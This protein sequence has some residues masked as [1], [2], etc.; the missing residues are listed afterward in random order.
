[1]CC[2]DFNLLHLCRATDVRAE[3]RC[4][5]EDT[6]EIEPKKAKTTAV[7][8]IDRC[9]SPCSSIASNHHSEDKDT[10]LRSDD[11]NH[12][13]SPPALK[14]AKTRQAFQCPHCLYSAN[15]CSSLN[16][17]MRIHFPPKEQC[18]SP[19]VEE[20]F[21]LAEIY[22]VECNIQFSSKATYLRHKEFYCESRHRG[23][24][25]VRRRSNSEHSPA[26]P[27]RG[28]ALQFESGSSMAAAI[29]S[30]QGAA[31][32]YVSS[33]Q[34][35][36]LLAGQQRVGVSPAVA[37]MSPL[38]AVSMS[39]MVA[40]AEMARSQAAA[41]MMLASPTL[42]ESG[43]PFSVPATVILQPLVAPP[44]GMLVNSVQAHHA[45]LSSPPVTSSNEQP[46]DL[47]LSK[48]SPSPR[49]ECDTKHEVQ[50]M[51][52]IQKTETVERL[53][54]HK[55]KEEPQDLSTCKSQSVSPRETCRMISPKSSPVPEAS[56]YLAA[57]G[58]QIRPPEGVVAPLPPI[59]VAPPV[60]PG[61]MPTL[62]TI[63]KCLECNI[64]FYKHENYVAHKEHYCAGRLNKPSAA[65]VSPPGIVRTSPVMAM[66]PSV[67]SPVCSTPVMSPGGGQT[68][69]MAEMYTVDHSFLHYYCIPCKI[70]FSSMD[71]LKAHKDYYCP[72]RA[73]EKVID[74]ATADTVT[75]SNS[76]SES[77]VENGAATC[78]CTQCGSVFPSARQL[79]HH[80]CVLPPSAPLPLFHCPYCDYV[81][82]SESRLTEHLKAHAPSKA[83]RC[84]LCGYRGNT[85]RGMR[86]HGKMHTDE[87]EE[88]TDDNITEYEEPPLLP[89]L[90]RNNLPSENAS[91][92][93][94]A[95]L[96]RLK[97]E[98]YKR[99][100]SRKCFEKAENTSLRRQ[101]PH[102]CVECNETFPDTCKLRV[103]MR[104]HLEEKTFCCRSCD[105]VSNSKSSLVRHVKL[106]HESTGVSSSGSS[107]CD[108]R[109]KSS[110]VAED[111]LSPVNNDMSPV[112][113]EEPLSENFPDAE[114]N[115]DRNSMSSPGSVTGKSHISIKHEPDVDDNRENVNIE[116]DKVTSPKDNGVNHQVAPVVH[117]S[118]VCIAPPAVEPLSP[119][120][121]NVHHLV[122]GGELS[123]LAPLDKCGAK[124]CKQCDI[125]FTYLST[126]IAHKKYYCSSHA[127]ER[128]NAQTEV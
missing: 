58:L 16:R 41:A 10:S 46:L 39:S 17:H 87:N 92:D 107:E 127:A 128:S 6:E 33:P 44:G 126:F 22:C 37:G 27:S 12:S 74:S 81:A 98:P 42:F 85:P 7:I 91:L 63:S 112:V 114:S 121:V 120:V 106:V 72:A 108:K 69:P 36:T 117:C 109:E 59:L 105:F 62:P 73:A 101:A 79:K 57:G 67:K 49:S 28:S 64:V 99:R 86:M 55:L 47:S 31:S 40:T 110:P 45:M 23:V 52:G 76:S 88:F 53:M 113:K 103:H 11:S 50:S 118:S 32:V 100:K 3:K 111:R 104:V 21:C 93:V 78:L 96:I 83:Y 19:V 1:M 71:T 35:M 30:S 102:V 77:R 84:T 56:N 18:S 82:Q 66:S 97:N 48:R 8:P 20:R 115:F 51:E 119:S 65:S 2:V 125:S 80:V 61:V 89:K 25:Y 70:K 75:Q 26:A 43:M 13:G 94:E 15:K 90:I 14:A 124:Y 123:A 122:T 38:S 5:E 29:L 4:G 9:K 60:P 24:A 68:Q 116:I 95:E 54:S 34:E